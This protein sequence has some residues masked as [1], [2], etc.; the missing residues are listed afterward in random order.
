MRTHLESSHFERLG[1]L[2][3]EDRVSQIQL[4]MVHRIF[5]GDVPKCLNYFYRVSK[6]YR[7]S[8]RG[9]TTDFVSPELKLISAQIIFCMLGLQFGTG[10]LVQ[11]SRSET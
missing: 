1:W 9:S 7:H 6:V 8:T 11:S 10:Y 3:V 4:C 2:K 5:Y